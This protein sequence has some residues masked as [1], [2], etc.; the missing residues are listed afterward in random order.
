MLGE[1]LEVGR[2]CKLPHICCYIMYTILQY[3]PAGVLKVMT[4]THIDGSSIDSTALSVP[5]LKFTCVASRDHDMFMTAIPTRTSPSHYT[6][7]API[8]HLEAAFGPV[9]A[10]LPTFVNHCAVTVLPPRE[11]PNNT[12]TERVVA[13]EMQTDAH[14]SVMIEKVPSARDSVRGNVGVRL[15]FPLNI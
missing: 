2:D 6:T 9:P 3:R 11:R 1:W 13:N 14:M 10:R 8:I 5:Q 12:R 7:I 4:Y 15:R